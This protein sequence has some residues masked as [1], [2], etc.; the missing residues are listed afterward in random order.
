M[1]Y[2]RVPADLSVVESILRE[3]EVRSERRVAVARGVLLGS[4][5][6]LDLAAWAGWVQTTLTRPSA[7]TVALDA[8]FLALAVAVLA[9]T[10]RPEYRPGLKYM[11]VTAD[12]AMIAAVLTLDPSVARGGAVGDWAALVAL[13]FVFMLNL[14]R[15]SVGATTYA[16]ALAIGL[17]GLF[18]WASAPHPN[19][20]GAMA[21]G[22][23]MLLGI[24]WAVT[25][26]NRAMLEEVAAKQLMERYLPPQLV[27]RLHGGGASLEP[28]GEA[29][30]VTIL[31]ADL[32]DFTTLAEALPAEAVVEVLNAALSRMADAV[33]AHEGTLDKFTG[34]GLMAIFG[35]PVA[36]ADDAARAVRAGLDMIAAVA[37]MAVPPALEGRGL[38][39]GVGIH[40]GSALVGNIGSVKRLDYTAVGDTVNLASRVEGLTKSMGAP[41]LVSRATRDAALAGPG[42]E[43]LE[44][45]AV[46]V[47]P[48]KGRVQPV[49]VFTARRGSAG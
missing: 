26:A 36:R 14:L 44:F 41:L 37:A 42:A 21:A 17:F 3:R 34:D 2:G 43:A 10:R 47:A 12:F 33:F 29:R 46:G 48:V 7:A 6:A 19:E 8:A 5:T 28:G 40:T 32:R 38:A 49:E 24:G 22:L 31:F 9:V 18:G 1:G 16:A 23:A 25:R 35:A 45:A 30:V 20:L 39:I 15:F 11:I 13:L 27:G 4:A